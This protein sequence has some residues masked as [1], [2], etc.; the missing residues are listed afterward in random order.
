MALVFHKLSYGQGYF[1]NEMVTILSY[2]YGRQYPAGCRYRARPYLL[3]DTTK[4]PSFST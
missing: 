3:P 2:P 4:V 1:D